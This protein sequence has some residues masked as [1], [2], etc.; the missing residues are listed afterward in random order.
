[1]EYCFSERR[2]C[3]TAS[4]PVAADT[5]EKGG[6]EDAARVSRSW[7]EEC[8]GGLEQGRPATTPGSSGSSW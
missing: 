3:G 7:W 1:M 2:G 5:T 8:Q 4:D 6:R